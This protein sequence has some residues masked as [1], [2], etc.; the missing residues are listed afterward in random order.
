MGFMIYGNGMNYDD[1]TNKDV[2]EYIRSTYCSVHTE[3][4]LPN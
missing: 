3:E 1:P 4:F 2:L